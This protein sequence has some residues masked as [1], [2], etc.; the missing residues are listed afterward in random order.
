MAESKIEQRVAELEKEL[1]TL[2]KK[3][4]SLTDSTPWWERIA[5]TFA[6]DPAYKKAMKLGQQYRKSQ[7][8]ARP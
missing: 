3:V 6:N 8:T 2:R 1:A 7:N 4:D 5:G